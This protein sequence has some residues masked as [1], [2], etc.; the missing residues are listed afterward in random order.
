MNYYIKK[1]SNHKI[2]LN[3]H[4]KNSSTHY[5]INYQNREVTH[6]NHEPVIFQ[7]NTHY[8]TFYAYNNEYIMEE[9]SGYIFNVDDNTAIGQRIDYGDIIWYNYYCNE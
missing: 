6:V 2:K 5:K 3:L 9:Y 7:D 8:V 4:K 1:M